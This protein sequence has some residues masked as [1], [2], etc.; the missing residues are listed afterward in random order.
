[1]TN[2]STLGYNINISFILEVELIHLQHNKPSPRYFIVIY[3]TFFFFTVPLY[4]S[5]D[6][7]WF[8]TV[9]IYIHFVYTCIAIIFVEDGAI[10][11]LAE[12]YIA[13]SA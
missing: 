2:D 4:K 11:L 3:M 5:G 12:W 6:L 7:F 8:L 9:S 1:M 10:R 13:P